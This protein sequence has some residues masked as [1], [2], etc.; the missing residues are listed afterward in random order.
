MK[1]SGYNK[2]VLK[3]RGGEIQKRASKCETHWGHVDLELATV[4]G[5]H[6]PSSGEHIGDHQVVPRCD[7]EQDSLSL[8]LKS[9]YIE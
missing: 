1:R 2:K 7:K 9:I 8:R 3:Q 6:F 4:V 5:K